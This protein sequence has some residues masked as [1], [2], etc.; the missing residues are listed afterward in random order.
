MDHHRSVCRRRIF[1]ALLIAVFAIPMVG[2][3]GDAGLSEF[4]ER[5]KTNV[6][7]VATSFKIFASRNQQKAPKDQAELVAFLA[8]DRVKKNIERLGIDP[9]EIEAIFVSDRD[10]QPLKIKWGI[11]MD[12][13]NT[14]PIA[15]ETVGVD[16]VRLVA[17]DVVLEVS[18][19]KEYEDLWNGIYEPE[20]MKLKKGLG[21]DADAPQ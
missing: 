21:K 9:D 19:D 1:N 8:E 14:L 4:K 12:P 2:C 13:E 20:W 15:F 17:A 5:N 10:G 18:D 6:A 16:G 3:G 11:E 7:K